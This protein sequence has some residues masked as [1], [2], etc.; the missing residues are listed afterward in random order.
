[1]AGVAAVLRPWLPKSGTNKFHGSAYEFLQNTAFES[2][3]FPANAANSTIAPYHYDD[4]GFS[5]GGPVIK[6]KTFGF[7]SYERNLSHG[8]GF[9][10]F[11]VPTAAERQGNFSHD[12]NSDG[13]LITIYDPTT[14]APDPANPGKYIRTA[15]PGN[16]I[17][18]T[19]QDPV[20]HKGLS[21]LAG[22]Q[23]ARFGDRQPARTVS[24]GEQ[25]WRLG[26]RQFARLDHRV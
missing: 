25:F 20:A 23:P 26:R 13:Q 3:S 12:F 11:S 7:F 19:E 22:G 14:T 18:T 24:T 6:N 21:L 8:G 17:P 1:M 9:S 5:V 2:N 4:Y 15:F 10:Q 16:I